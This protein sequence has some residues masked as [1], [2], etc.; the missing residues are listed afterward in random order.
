M[1][2]THSIALMD[3]ILVL[4]LPERPFVR[5]TLVNKPAITKATHIMKETFSIALMDVIFVLA[6]L[7]RSLV[8]K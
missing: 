8:Q 3:V 7:D 2:E 5:Q 4:A 6:H 1:Q